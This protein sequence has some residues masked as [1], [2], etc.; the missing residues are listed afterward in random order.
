M[1][2][3]LDRW[4][5]RV[6]KAGWDPHSAFVVLRDRIMAPAD[7]LV[8][9]AGCNSLISLLW[10]LSAQNS[11][12]VGEWTYQL[13]RSKINAGEDA[14]SFLV[15]LRK[16]IMPFSNMRAR[17]AAILSSRSLERRHFG[18]GCVWWICIALQPQNNC[19]RFSRRTSKT[20][21]VSSDDRQASKKKKKAKRNETTKHIIQ[22]KKKTQDTMHHR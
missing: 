7:A 12:Q 19:R 14:L 16:L 1:A 21:K 15:R 2:K 4:P 10:R 13:E 17:F 5:E 8:T 6:E 22:D 3:L 20:H 11:H 18:T 9:T